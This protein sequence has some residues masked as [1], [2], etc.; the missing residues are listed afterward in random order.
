M[1]QTVINKQIPV[2]PFIAGQPAALAL[3]LAWVAADTVNGNSFA[4]SGHEILLVWNT[5][6]SIN[7]TFTIS[8][9]ADRDQ[10]S[11]D[12]TAYQ[13]GFGVISAFSFLGATEGWGQAGGTVNF[14]GANASLKFAVLSV[15][16]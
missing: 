16:R 2:G 6:A 9:V 7:Y 12:V 3:D 15:N 13:V 11:Q 4:L 5:H 8:S 1:P 14:L 10:R